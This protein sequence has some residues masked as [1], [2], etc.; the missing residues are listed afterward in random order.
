MET[1]VEHDLGLGK[2]GNHTMSTLELT[3]LINMSS[4]PGRSCRLP[5][6]SS[7]IEVASSVEECIPHRGHH[8]KRVRKVEHKVIVNNVDYDRLMCG[9]ENAA[10]M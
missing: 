5:T 3:G 8:G 6:A 2:C 10:V 7:R 1:H 9:V 4:L